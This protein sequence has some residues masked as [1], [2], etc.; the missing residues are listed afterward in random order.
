MK[1]YIITVV[2]L[3]CILIFGLFVF[4]Y[5]EQLL[6]SKTPVDV[7][8]VEETNAEH[9]RLLS[10]YIYDN[11]DYQWTVYINPVGGGED[12]GNVCGNLSEA[13]VTLAIAKYVAVLNQD[14]DVRIVLSRDTDT[15][16]SYEQRM[17]IFNA[18]KPDM[19]IEL[20]AKAD[21]KTRAAGIEAWYDD[22]Y[23]NYKL[24]NS[25]FAD[26]MC[27]NIMK[28]CECEVSSIN[29]DK[30]ASYGCLS[31]SK[32]PA[33]VFFCGNIENTEEK[34]G[35]ASDVYRANMALGILDTIEECRANFLVE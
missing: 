14:K 20:R 33:V 10:A 30:D 8:I 34:T 15:N 24:T 2:I 28:R 27:K 1:K 5:R 21:M 26:K 7:A 22:S 4:I 23:Y 9:E 35:L 18:T 19:I 11:S 12:R 3:L 32:N 17:E 29:V 31:I 25:D 6:G 13:E 16:P